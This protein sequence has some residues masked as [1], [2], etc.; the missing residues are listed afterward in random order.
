M[1]LHILSVDDDPFY[2]DLYQ[3]LFEAKGYE[4]SSA[5][6]PQEGYDAAMKKRPDIILLDVMMPEKGE[7]KDGFSLLEGLR[8]KQ[9]FSTTPILMV[10]ALGND[11]DV[12]HGMELGATDYLP[13]QDAT[14]DSLLRKV[15]KLL[16]KKPAP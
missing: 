8:K 1:P 15:K 13:K 11:D 6:D 10:S 9:Q 3:T 5:L 7:F 12:R 2:R 14:P 4:F 16:D